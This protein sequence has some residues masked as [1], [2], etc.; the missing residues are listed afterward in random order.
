MFRMI[1]LFVAL[2]TGGS[3]A[4]LMAA[5]RREP[6]AAVAVAR[7][8]EPAATSVDVLVVSGV[9]EQGQVLT[10]ENLRWRPWPEA[11][12]SP[13]FITRATNADAIDKLAGALVRTRLLDR[14]PVQADK[15]MALNAGMLSALLPTGQRAVAVRITAE[16]TAGGFILPNDR[17][18]VLHTVAEDG[19]KGATQRHASR[20]I[21]RN[22]TVLAIDQALDG[23]PDEQKKARP[24]TIGK[25]ATLQLT[26]AQS[27][28]ITEAEASGTLSLALRSARDNAEVPVEQAAYSTIRVV[29]GG[30]TELV[31]TPAQRSGNA[32]QS[33]PSS[34]ASPRKG[35]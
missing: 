6:T 33:G 31:R 4:W 8:S 3:A 18:D 10:R 9:V 24:A 30:R 27:E 2:A 20:T 14:E 35:T 13:V 34:V 17:V 28:I 7:A 5:A 1:I 15:L 23:A 26:P 16:T 21:L 12:L 22:V 29:R 11:G 19:L 25:T 32:I